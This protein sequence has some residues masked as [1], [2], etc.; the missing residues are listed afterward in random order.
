M[1]YYVPSGPIKGLG[2]GKVLLK[3]LG[4]IGKIIR[5]SLRLPVMMLTTAIAS[6][7]YIEYKLSQLSAPTWVTGNLEKMRGWLEGV[8]ESEWLRSSSSSDTYST[9]ED[10]K[11]DAAI[12]KA[13]GSGGG[14]GGG[15]GT[16]GDIDPY[17]G[18]NGVPP[19]KGD[20]Y[21]SPEPDS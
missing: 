7:A 10:S 14:W 6:L 1:R 18:G 17:S 11:S 15:G 3:L 5:A 20:Y 21:T 9:T 12:D 4:S 13:I 2:T 19:P 16:D 8:R